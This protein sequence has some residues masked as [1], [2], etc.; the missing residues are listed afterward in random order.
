MIMSNWQNAPFLG[1]TLYTITTLHSLQ[2][3]IVYYRGLY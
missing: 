2:Y 1:D 3:C